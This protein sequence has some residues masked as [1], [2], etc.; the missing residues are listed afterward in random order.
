MRPASPILPDRRFRDR[1]LLT[2]DAGARRPSATPR[3]ALPLVITMSL[4]ALAP[5]LLADDRR[6]WVD[7]IAYVV[8]TEKFF[9]GDPSNDIMRRR[10]GKDRDAL[11]GGLWGGDLE[12]VIR[13]LDHLADLGVTTLLIY[14]VVAND[15]GRFGRW[16]PGTGYRPRDYFRGR[17]EPRRHPHAPPAGRPRPTVAA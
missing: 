11:G 16:L 3:P 7:E 8:I 12:G 5:P 9:D 15:T 10:F 1:R 13:K 4:A 6:E 14:P 2:N 17:R